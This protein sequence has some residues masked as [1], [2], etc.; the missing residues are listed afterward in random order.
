M[1]VSVEQKLKDLAVSE[2]GFVFDPYSG[3][4][5]SVNA[6]GLCLLEG[7]KSG[8]DRNGLIERLEES[9]DVED[10]ELGRDVDEFLEL[11]RHHAILP[12]AARI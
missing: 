8:L 2:S 6:T 5:F 1:T 11:L 7:M 12:A 4:T 10:A 9:F 3:A